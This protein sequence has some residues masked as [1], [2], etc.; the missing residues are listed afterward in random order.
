MLT[1]SGISRLSTIITELSNGDKSSC[2]ELKFPQ[3]F[4][5]VSECPVAQNP[6]CGSTGLAFGPDNIFS[7][8][9]VYYFTYFADPLYSAYT[10]YIHDYPNEELRSLIYNRNIQLKN[11]CD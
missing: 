5:W 6:N 7:Q 4:D 10:K 9:D 11:P 3:C 2:S 1:T 8:N